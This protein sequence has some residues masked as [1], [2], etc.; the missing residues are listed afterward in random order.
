MIKELSLSRTREVLSKY[1]IEANNYILLTSHRPANVDNKENIENILQ[2]MIE[3][4]NISN[5]IILF[6]IHPRTKNNIIKF[7]LESLLE[8]FIVIEPV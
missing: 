1:D 3:L 7:G 6:P 5:K 2:A 8:Q 4:K